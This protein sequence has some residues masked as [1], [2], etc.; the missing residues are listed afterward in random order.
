MEINNVAPVIALAIL[1]FTKL[2][3]IHGTITSFVREP[4]SIVSVVEGDDIGQVDVFL[5]SVAPAEEHHPRCTV[6]SPSAF[7][8]HSYN[9]Q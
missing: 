6:P 4:A 1:V 3:T 8:I 5:A 2:V 7:V 9:R